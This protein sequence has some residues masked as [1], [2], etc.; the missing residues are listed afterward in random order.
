MTNF[1]DRLKKLRIEKELTQDNLAQKFSLNKSSISRYEK[2]LQMPEVQTLIYFADF[3]HVSVDYLLC[4]TD[5]QN[6]F[7]ELKDIKNCNHVCNEDTICDVGKILNNALELLNSKQ[8]VILD[9]KI[10]DEIDIEILTKSIMNGIEYAK[11]SNRRGIY[12]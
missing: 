11:I 12:K 3:F 9:G 2:N 8:T 1:G 10:L 5:K 4:R 6:T 7:S